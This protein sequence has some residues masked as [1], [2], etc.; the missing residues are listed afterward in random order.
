MSQAVIDSFSGEWRVL[1]NF[2][3]APR[4]IGGLVYDTAEHW[5]HA[6]KAISEQDHER[7]RI[8][9][10]PRDAKRLGRDIVCRA[11]WE[12]VKLNVMRQGL[13]HKFVPGGPEA[14]K[15][16][17]T[18]NAMLV[19][20]NSWGDTFWGQVGGN[21]HNWLG[22]LL[23]AQRAFLLTCLQDPASWLAQFSEE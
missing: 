6:N 7:I 18:G 22:W 15:L 17:A 8:T 19:E 23:M 12:A 13:F 20:G 5:F 3:Y 14:H 11:D 1:S 2:Y 16:L 21:G 9:R 10:S 4:D